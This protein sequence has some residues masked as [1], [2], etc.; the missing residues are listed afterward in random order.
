MSV[1]DVAR[2]LPDISALTGLCRSLAVLDAIL[3]PEWD[4]RWHSFDARWSPTEEAA[5]MRDGSGGEYTVVFSAAGAYAR[6]FDH[7]SPMSPHLADGPWPGVLDDVP[8]VFRRYVEEPR[9]TDE[10]GLPEVTACL[11]RE[12]TDDRW[13]AGS[14]EFPEDGEDSDGADWLFQLLVAGTPES[15]QE[16]AEDHFEVAVDLAAVRH[17]YALRPLTDEVV[18]A[19][20]PGRG[21]AE[22]AADIEETGYPAAPTA[23]AATPPAA[24]GA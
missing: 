8:A 16:W 13:R 23:P 9:F 20:A 7:E 18:A 22:L 4:H 11:W 15:Y 21:L 6:G 3:C 14:V 1:H 10:D 24:T 5:S 19:L 2:G 17:V 12:S